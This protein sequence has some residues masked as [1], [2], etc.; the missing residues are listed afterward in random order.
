[1]QGLFQKSIVVAV[2]LRAAADA[3]VAAAQPPLTLAQLGALERGLAAVEADSSESLL[4]SAGDVV[5]RALP[6]TDAAALASSL[7]AALAPGSAVL[8][9]EAAELMRIAQALLIF[10]RCGGFS[11]A[12]GRYEAPA[13]PP[14]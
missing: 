12:P 9:A 11:T 3:R 5:A 8:Q 4:E 2:C 10:G 6:D 1:M 14:A 7:R 13:Q